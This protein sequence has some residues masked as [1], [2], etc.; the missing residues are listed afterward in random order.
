MDASLKDLEVHFISKLGHL[1]TCSIPQLVEGIKD[2]QRKLYSWRMDFFLDK[3]KSVY[4]ED[5]ISTWTTDGFDD[6]H[7]LDTIPM[8]I[9][10][11]FDEV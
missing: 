7:C 6:N 1:Y 10:L 5:P 8:Q 4:L 3:F 9:T 11:N 2:A